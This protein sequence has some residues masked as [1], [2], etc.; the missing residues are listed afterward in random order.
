MQVA[1]DG[2][3][4]TIGMASARCRLASA[5]LDLSMGHSSSVAPTCCCICPRIL[6]NDAIN[7]LLCRPAPLLQESDWGLLMADHQAKE[8]YAK[9]RDEEPDSAAPAA[10]APAAAVPKPPP[11]EIRFLDDAVVAAEMDATASSAADVDAEAAAGS[12]S[13]PSTAMARDAALTADLQQLQ[14]QFEA[15]LLD[16][17][18]APAAGALG[19][20]DA[21]D[22]IEVATT[23][24]FDDEIE[25]SLKE[26]SEN[27]ETLDELD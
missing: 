23:Q 5:L 8:Y 20:G 25:R 15:D 4:Y 1:V 14:Q 13:R 22:G 9:K 19:R 2:A 7:H 26:M 3:I 21:L 27:G 17:D 11:E 10:A 12:S 18:E 24:Q 16:D 6:N